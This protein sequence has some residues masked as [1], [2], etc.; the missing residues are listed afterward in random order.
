MKR[1]IFALVT[2]T[3]L[4]VIS[5]NCFSQE[6]N[7]TVKTSFWASLDWST[8][9]YIALSIVASIFSGIFVSLKTKLRQLGN[10]SISL[11]DA[12][13]DKKIDANEKTDLA[14]KVKE[15]LGKT[16]K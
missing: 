13:E 11:A 15:L 5:L 7:E 8:I 6:T 3:M 4:I 16:A 14:A 9:S 2:F 12:I 10:L 1:F